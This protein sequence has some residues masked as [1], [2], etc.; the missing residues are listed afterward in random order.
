MSAFQKAEA[1]ATQRY[2]R[3]KL[4][5]VVD[6]VTTHCGQS[7]D[8]WRMLLIVAADQP[9]SDAGPISRRGFGRSGRLASI[10]AAGSIGLGVHAS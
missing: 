4:L 1:L 6:E 3:D 7:V 9:C 5:A 2:D 8:T 10:V